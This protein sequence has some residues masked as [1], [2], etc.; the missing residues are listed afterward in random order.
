MVWLL[1]TREFSAVKPVSPA[2]VF[3][4]CRVKP[5]IL[6]QSASATPI[7]KKHNPLNLNLRKQTQ[8]TVFLMQIFIFV[9]VCKREAMSARI[10]PLA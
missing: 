6:S 2:S 10:S 9:F 7:N 3:C 5:D 8:R 1:S 4:S